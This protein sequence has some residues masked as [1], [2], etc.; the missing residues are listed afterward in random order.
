MWKELGLNIP[1]P[2]ETKGEEECLA[3]IS[4]SL[5]GA[6]PHGF[7]G[8]FYNKGINT[9]FLRKKSKNDS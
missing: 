2:E 1:H 4:V 6:S 7:A 3:P 9:L 5:H 8:L